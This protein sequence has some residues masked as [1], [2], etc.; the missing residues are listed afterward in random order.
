MTPLHKQAIVVGAGLAG[1]ATAR[2]LAERGWNI[3]VL[4]MADSLGQGGSGVPVGVMSCH[5]SVDDN[6]LSQ[7]TREGMQWTRRF[8]Q[9]HLEEGIDWLGNGVLERRLSP[10]GTDKKAWQEPAEGSVWQGHVLLASDEQLAQADL[11]PSSTQS[12]WQGQG[13]WIKPQALVQ[14]LLNHTNISVLRG[15][16]VESMQRQ[17]SGEWQLRVK[18][19]NRSS[20]TCSSETVPHVVLALGAHIRDFLNQVLHVDHMGLHPIAGMV[21]WGFQDGISGLP[22]FAVNGHGSFVSGVPKQGG[23][24]WYTGATF[25]R[26]AMQ[27]AT[28]EAAQNENQQRLGELLPA[29]GARLQAQ[30]ANTAH[31]KTWG[32]VRCASVNRLP[33]LGPLDDHHFPGLYVL[34]AMGSRGLTL[35][36]LCAEVLAAQ[37]EK[38]KPP[39]SERL[40]KAMRC[41]L[42]NV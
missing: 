17:A 33:K 41:Q 12:L 21:S 40:L 32:G 9:A 34:A 31:M 42:L 29:V 7:L 1:A 6:P 11:A 38:S 39:V 25:E 20:F 36:L 4:E 16:E 14:A 22:P 2:A 23:A 30:F 8:A 19:H 15:A 37:I 10:V 27:A 18:T 5:V 35:S 13:G 3:K 24:A 28:D 26:H